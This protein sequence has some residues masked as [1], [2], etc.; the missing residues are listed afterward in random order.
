M[1]LLKD[2]IHTTAEK[3]VR[4][5]VYTDPSQKRSF[6]KALF[7]TEEK[8]MRLQSETSVSKFLRPS[9]DGGLIDSASGRT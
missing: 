1:L 8:L 2:L 4:P 6:S 9:V 5:A 3:L 7:K